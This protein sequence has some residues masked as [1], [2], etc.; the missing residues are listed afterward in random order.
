M[1]IDIEKDAEYWERVANNLMLART[2]LRTRGW[3]QNTMQDSLG[4]VC[5]LGAIQQAKIPGLV[6]GECM[7]AL[8]ET[9]ARDDQ[10][11]PARLKWQ[12]IYRRFRRQGEY[13]ISKWRVISSWNDSKFRT[14]DH[15]YRLF[16][17]TIR[18]CRDRARRLRAAS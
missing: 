14:E 13:G 18:R 7:D 16:N 4:R 17:V 5:S 1:N 12:R 9:I 8:I 10:G 6:Y 11:G 15:V 2:E 3:T